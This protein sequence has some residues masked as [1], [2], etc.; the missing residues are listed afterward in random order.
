[1][2]ATNNYAATQVDFRTFTRQVD[3]LKPSDEKTK[4][5][6]HAR[7]LLLTLYRRILSVLSLPWDEAS[8]V[9]HP[10]ACIMVSKRLQGAATTPEALG[11]HLG[12]RAGGTSRRRN[13]KA[14]TTRA[15]L[16]G[17]SHGIQQEPSR[18]TAAKDAK[19]MQVRGCGGRRCRPFSRALPEGGF[20]ISGLDSAQHTGH[21]PTPIQPH[22]HPTPIQRG[23]SD[24]PFR[25]QNLGFMI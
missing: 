24:P 25:F 11:K 10:P 14:G 16:L 2:I 5:L 4:Y 6:E 15:T 20:A 3:S 18:V 21:L 19:G 12:S 13:A 22:T 9:V 17:S 23:Q 8:F 7:T 1:M